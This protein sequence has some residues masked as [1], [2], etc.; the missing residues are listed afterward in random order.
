MKLA[1]YSDLHT[2]HSVFEAPDDLDAD[3]IVLAGDIHTPG[4]TTPKWARRDSLFGDRPVVYV[5]GNHE[6]YEDECLAQ[7]RMMQKESDRWGVHFLD[8]RAVVIDGVRFI[9]CTLWTDFRL[10]IVQPDGSLRSDVERSMAESG[11]YMNDYACIKLRQPIGDRRNGMRRTLR[12]IDTLAFHERERRWLEEE[13]ARPFDGPTVVVT[14]HAP[15]RQSLAAEFEADWMSGAYVSELPASF[16][17]V[18]VLWVHGH[19][20]T[21][22]DYRVGN[23]RV[24]CNPRGYPQR[25]HVG[26]ENEAFDPKGLEIEVHIG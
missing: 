25:R 23:C 4:H 26:H 21:S 13:L 19:T 15:H 6:F 8:A 24:V 2:E 22:F 3:V 9:G 10:G 16:F 12:P 5:A 7:K 20:H 11:R 14:H 1:I 18:P 17:E